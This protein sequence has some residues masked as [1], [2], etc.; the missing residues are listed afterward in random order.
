MSAGSTPAAS[1]MR[2]VKLHNHY[3]IPRQIVSKLIEY[4]RIKSECDNIETYMSL[5]GP[6]DRLRGSIPGPVAFFDSCK[7]QENRG[8][9]AHF[10]TQKADGICLRLG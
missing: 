2:K 9:C 3:R 6:D 10:S 4:W 5:T 7:L 8:Q 1:T